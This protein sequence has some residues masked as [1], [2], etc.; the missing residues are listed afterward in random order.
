[1]TT[2]YGIKNCDTIRKAR[3]WLD[4]NG[5]AYTFHDFRT[6]GLDKKM[7]AAWVKELGW[8]QLINRRGTTWRN[9]SGEEKDG[10]TERKAIELML[11]HPAVIKR[12]VLDIDTS[13]V[14][15]FIEADY[16]KIFN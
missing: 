2:L 15:G 11:A 1:M 9:L 12:P 8:E 3:K 4:G 16:K 6:D 7:L 14:V 5:I 13:R 10:L